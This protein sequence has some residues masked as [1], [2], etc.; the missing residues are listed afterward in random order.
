LDSEAASEADQPGWYRLLPVVVLAVGLLLTVLL[1]METRQAL[2]EATDDSSAPIHALQAQRLN[3]RLTQQEQLLQLLAGSEDT[4]AGELLSAMAGWQGLLRLDS[5][6]DGEL[7][8]ADARLA[9]NAPQALATNTIKQPFWNQLREQLPESGPL[10]TPH[11]RVE[12]TLVQGL[13]VATGSD[14]DTQYLVN[15]FDPETLIAENLKLGKKP[16]LRISVMD[17]QQHDPLPLY[18][19]HDEDVHEPFHETTIRIGNRQWLVRSKSVG[20]LDESYGTLLLNVLLFSGVAL[21]I[22]LTL[23]TW[24]LVRYHRLNLRRMARMDRLRERDRRALENKR[25]EKE[26]M[27]RALSD[28]E[29]RTRDFIQLGGGMGFELDDQQAIGFVSAQVQ[30]L[31]GRAPSDLAGLALAELV[32]E[33]EHQRLTDAFRSSKRERTITRLDTCL[34]HKDGTILPVRIQIC[35]VCDALSHCQGFRAVA[36]PHSPH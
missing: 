13:V 1:W 16:R 9:D 14:I 36:W 34:L 10:G 32:P 27:T 6:D 31:L 29:Q 28:S 22:A 15:L 17:L 8:V 24:Q 35:T 18:S 23:L 5:G 3:D 19:N 7:Q 4:G 20:A 33:T 12:G 25:V 21:S 30:P 26:V 11:F 2:I